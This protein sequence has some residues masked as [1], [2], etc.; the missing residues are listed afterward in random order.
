MKKIHSPKLKRM[1]VVHLFLCALIPG[2]LSIAFNSNI[3]GAYASSR[4][5]TS[6]IPEGTSELSTTELKAKLLNNTSTSTT[7]RFGIQFESTQTV[8][9]HDS[10]N[11]CQIGF[12]DSNFSGDYR[13]PWI[14]ESGDKTFNGYAIRASIANYKGTSSQELI[15]SIPETLSYGS[16]YTINVTALGSDDFPFM[17]ADDYKNEKNRIT[18]IYIPSSVKKVYDNA[19]INIPSDVKLEI[20]FENKKDAISFVDEANWLKG[21]GKDLVKVN[22]EVTYDGTRNAK[23]SGTPIYFGEACS[24]VLG[25]KGGVVDEKTIPELLLSYEYQ[26]EV[27]QTVYYKQGTLNVKDA[28]NPY[29]AVSL[30]QST[31]DTEVILDL[32]FEE[33]Y[34]ENSLVFYNIYPLISKET[35]SGGFIYFPDT[36]KPY[37]AHSIKSYTIDYDIANVVDYSFKE[38]STF[39]EY[40]NVVTNF[41]RVYLGEDQHTL[42]QEARPQDF[43]SYSKQFASGA[44]IIR[45]RLSN[46]STSN[47]VIEYENKNGEIVKATTKIVSPLPYIVLNAHGLTA[48][49]FLIKNSD[50]AKD[51]S[52]DKIRSIK[53]DTLT[54]NMHIYDVE[55]SSSLGLS[56]QINCT[57]GEVYLLTP[58]T[59]KIHSFNIVTFILIFTISL[60]VAFIGVSIAL[61]FFLKE[62]YK[63]DEFRR[64]NTKRYVRTTSIGLLGTT[65]FALGLQFILFRFLKLNNSF[66]VYNP[67]DPYVIGFGI[68]AFIAFGYFIYFTI[69]FIKSEKKRREA[70]RLKLNE[71]IVDDGTK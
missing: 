30:N 46:L 66:A 63:N 15:V 36:S 45:Y 53:I 8:S 16:Q 35:A 2:A 28:N 68:A 23:V 11:L 40:T 33:T 52:A 31:F 71:D 24:F 62:K 19:F 55:N 20:N 10:T 67:L 27:D 59:E 57:F 56:N 5:S 54:I 44:Y 22:Y 25:Y 51:F 43:K 26:V 69:R 13:N 21:E 41:E 64:M 32:E 70:I 38:I 47:Y 29:D 14:D 1:G 34:V 37:Y 42:Y 6:L 4:S 60:I 9:L 39:G 49:S 58:V 17:D 3:S 61:Y 7:K 18:K 48:C 50:V 12:D 65:I